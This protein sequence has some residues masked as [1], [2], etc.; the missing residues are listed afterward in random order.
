MNTYLV[1]YEGAHNT[2]SGTVTASSKEQAIACARKAWG[3]CAGGV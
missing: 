3:V 2:L 1:T